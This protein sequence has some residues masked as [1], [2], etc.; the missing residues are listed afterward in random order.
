MTWKEHR[1]LRHAGE[2][3]KGTRKLIRMQRDVLDPRQVQ[4]VGAAAD[5]LQHAIAAKDVA[6]I[7][8]LSEKLERQLEKTFPRHK[9]SAWRENV[10][11]FLVAAIVA[12][13]VRTFFFQPF[14]IPTGSMQPTLNGILEDPNYDVNRPF[15]SRW[16]DIL[17]RGKGPT[18]AHSSVPEGVLDLLS[19]GFFGRWPVNGVCQARGDH[20]FVDRFTYHFRKPKRGE[21]VVFQTGFMHERGFDPR[22]SFY[23]K[24][25]VAKG[26]DHVEIKQPYLYVNGTLLDERPAFRRIYSLRDDY[27]GY[28]L[29][30]PY[31]F[32]SPPKYLNT[33]QPA[34]DVPLDQYLVLGDNT[35]RSL[36]GRYWGGVPKNALVGRGVFVYWPI[37]PHFGSIE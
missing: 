23:I 9:H 16:V 27:R 4:D 29:P 35:D 1:A 17:F 7:N 19:W 34:Y 22:G 31:G 26:G 10:E 33:R 6:A 14:K 8:G 25:L 21:V 32:P 30:E 20:I 5:D 3:A 37:V 15:V 11:V 12:M 13:G 18:N 24:R 2:L 36:D 28:V